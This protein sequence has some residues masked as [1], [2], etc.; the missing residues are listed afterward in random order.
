MQRPRTSLKR[1]ASNKGPL[2]R[3]WRSLFFHMFASIMAV[4][5]AIL[6]AQALVM[7]VMMKNQERE[8]SADVFNT[9][10]RRLQESLDQGVSAD[11]RWTLANVQPVIKRVA[12]D[13]VSGLIL[14][15]ANGET[16]LTFGKTPKG[17]LI[18]A[19]EG[20]AVSIQETPLGF[21]KLTTTQWFVDSAFSRLY[22]DAFASGLGHGVVMARY[23]EP[24]RRQDVVGTVVLYED[25]QRTRVF[26]S[27]DV[28]VF[29]PRDY[30]MTALLMRRMV[31]ALVITIPIALIVA[32]LG[33]RLIAKSVSRH[34]KR[35]SRMLE[36]IADGGAPATDSASSLNELADIATSAER[37]DAQLKD[38]ERIRRQW[39]Q[40]IAHDLNTP[41]AA[42][43]ISIEG[44]LDGVLPLDEALLLRL[45]KENEE[46]EKRVASVLTLSAMDEPDFSVR[47]DPI[48]ALDF[49]DEVVKSALLERR[50]TLDVQLD[51]FQGDRRL[52]VL[53]CREL[54]KNACK[55]SPSGTPVVWRLL[56]PDSLSHSVVMTV[57]NEGN[58]EGTDLERVFEPWFRLDRSRHSEGAG[59]GLSIV[60]QVVQLHGGE[61]T[62]ISDGHDRITVRATW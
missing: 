53:V 52:L 42:L 60:R 50:I 24:V 20:S 19:V 57:E 59:L 12:D 41:V 21:E 13:R 35:V 25:S 6:V 48:E 49:V 11:V 46:L 44:A 36:A 39:L 45:R 43:K 3:R 51:S 58:L 28:L 14:R 31:Q 7:A 40:S 62:M 22:V 1:G 8:F 15:D 26:G 32:L 5:L 56:P 10:A 30:S 37:L 16:V 54:L 18:P 29:S 33:A 17:L 47:K 27:V 34:A 4:T 2:R 38:H 9:F 61:V 23:P 55:Y